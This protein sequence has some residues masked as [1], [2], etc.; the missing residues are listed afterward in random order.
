MSEVQ[1]LRKENFFFLLILFKI[2]PEKK[3]KIN[4]PLYYI[5]PKIRIKK[6]L[7]NLATFG[8]MKVKETYGISMS[9]FR[10]KYSDPGGDLS[11]TEVFDSLECVKSR[12]ES[13]LISL[14]L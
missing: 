14:I 12:W 9:S 5:V 13:Y 1:S 8:R 7:A 11:K 2:I 4:F 6:K 3:L 10:F